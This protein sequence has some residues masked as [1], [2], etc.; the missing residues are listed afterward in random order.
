M[1]IFNIPKENVTF[2]DISNEYTNFSFVSFS[3]YFSSRSNERN[4]IFFKHF[5][6][7][8]RDTQII[9]PRTVM[10][11]IELV[12]NILLSH[13]PSLRLDRSPPSS[14]S[15]QLDK[16]LQTFFG[17]NIT[18]NPAIPSSRSFHPPMIQAT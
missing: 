16:K 15:S 11:K 10:L 18:N 8:S 1:R 9:L 7:I 17:E 13:F 2:F 3:V 5:S 6:F 4:K 14:H 12:S